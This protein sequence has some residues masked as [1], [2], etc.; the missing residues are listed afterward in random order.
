[1]VS[2]LSQEMLNATMVTWMHHVK[3]TKTL[4]RL[5][6]SPRDR[7]ILLQT[8]SAAEAKLLTEWMLAAWAKTHR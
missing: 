5:S 1:M 2:E 3:D 8:I 7:M 6:D 4:I